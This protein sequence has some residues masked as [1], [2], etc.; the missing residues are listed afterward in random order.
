M[1]KKRSGARYDK[2]SGLTDKTTQSLQKKLTTLLEKRKIE[3]YDV[4][5]Q[6]DKILLTLPTHLEQEACDKLTKAVMEIPGSENIKIK[7][8][9]GPKT[10][11]TDTQTEDEFSRLVGRYIPKEKGI[12]GSVRDGVLTVYGTVTSAHA[13]DAAIDIAKDMASVKKVV[14]ATK[15]P[16][17]KGDVE[18]ANAVMLEL[19]HEPNVNVFHLQVMA[20]NGYVFLTGNARD[21]KSLKLT[22][23]IVSK[24]P[25]VKSVENGIKMHTD[26]LT[27]DDKL[28]DSVLVELLRSPNVRAR[29]IKVTAIHGHIFLRGYAASTKEIIAAEAMVSSMKGVKK[30]YMELEPRL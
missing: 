19:G 26:G 28:R 11:M 13:R 14:D 17:A 12:S 2:Q 7:T 20:R 1:E 30:V 27:D 3:G 18:L 6:K 9:S 22:Q 16:E 4:K 25:G 8:Q 23:D 21:D 10:M 15:I 29:D 5:L 24:V